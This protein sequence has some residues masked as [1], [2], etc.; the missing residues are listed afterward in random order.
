MKTIRDRY[1]IGHGFQEE[2]GTKLEPELQP[3]RRIIDSAAEVNGAE[4]IEKQLGR[5]LSL[6]LQITSEST[7]IE[8][9]EL[10]AQQC[11]R[12]AHWSQTAWDHDRRILEQ[13]AV[14]RADLDR[15]RAQAI[16]CG[17]DVKIT[18]SARVSADPLLD[19]M[20]KCHA[21]SEIANDGIYSH[22]EPT[23]PDRDPAGNPLPLL[24]KPKSEEKRAV[25]S[26]R[27]RLLGLASGKGV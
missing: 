17:A 25:T 11:H 8:T 18:D 5:D 19:C 22:P 14:G 12:C 3:V 20:G 26:I 4:N 21:L 2:D 27:D 15:M 16:D 23:C 13:T 10:L 7:A 1:Q 24:F 6:P 9:A